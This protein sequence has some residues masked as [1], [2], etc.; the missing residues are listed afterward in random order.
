MAN[1]ANKTKP[2]EETQNEE[3]Q[4]KIPEVKTEKPAPEGKAKEKKPVRIL[5]LEIRRVPKEKKETD[6]N[7][8]QPNKGKWSV[9]KAVAVTTGCVAGIKGLVEITGMI[10]DTVYSGNKGSRTENGPVYQPQTIEGT[11]QDIPVSEPA[12]AETMND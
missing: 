10:L 4:E 7:T 3:Q 2:I 8:E 11:F 1:N 12:V 9:A 6:K 5:G